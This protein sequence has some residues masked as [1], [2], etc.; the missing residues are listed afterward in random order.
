M[1][2]G[3]NPTGGA[4]FK[5]HRKT[6][7]MAED[8]RIN[9]STLNVLATQADRHLLIN[10]VDAVYTKAIDSNELDVALRAVE[11]LIQLSKV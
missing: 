11:L 4:K 8:R 3:S 5:Q 10:K 9:P 6:H 2:V 1:V 7:I